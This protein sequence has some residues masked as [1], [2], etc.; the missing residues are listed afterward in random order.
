MISDDS[1]KPAKEN[2]GMDSVIYLTINSI[3]ERNAAC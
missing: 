3:V 1:A 2:Y